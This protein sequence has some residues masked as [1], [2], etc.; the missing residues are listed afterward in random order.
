M[1]KVYGNPISLLFSGKLGNMVGTIRNG[2]Q[3]IR[4]LPKK[5]SK[6]P[7]AKQIAHRARFCFAS[8]F[9]R[10]IR[11]I[12]Q[13][14]YNPSRGSKY[15]S[16]YNMAM[17]CL[18][19]NVVTGEYPDFSIDFKN[20]ELSPNK[21]ARLRKATIKKG[22]KNI[23][24]KW[25]LW[26]KDEYDINRHKITMIGITEE[27][28]LFYSDSNIMQEDQKGRLA[29]PNIKTGTNVYCYIAKT[30]MKDKQRFSGCSYI[31]VVKW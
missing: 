2:K 26:N 27:H 31:G 11:P 9:I 10:S 16:P 15:T 21:S 24:F 18:M 8:N 22:R 3:Y 20:L 29:V 6:E 4:S 7:T 17:A 12:I 5:S 1:A 28:Q 19:K 25:K 23:K 30:D 13:I 14:G